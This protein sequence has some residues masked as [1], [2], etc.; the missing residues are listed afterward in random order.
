MNLRKCGE[1]FDIKG[2]KDWIGC[3]EFNEEHDKD[4]VIWKRVEICPF[5]LVVMQQHPSHHTKNLSIQNIISY[6]NALQEHLQTLYTLLRRLI[7]V[8]LLLWSPE[9]FSKSTM[10]LTKASNV[11]KHWKRMREGLWLGSVRTL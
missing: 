5:C 1:Y 3:I 9:C 6:I 4:P 2:L 11:L 7:L 10:S 8:T